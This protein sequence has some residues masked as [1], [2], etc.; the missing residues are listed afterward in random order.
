MGLSPRARGNRCW[1][2]C[3]LFYKG[4]IPACAGEPASS[5]PRVE[6]LWAYPRVRGGTD[7]FFGPDLGVWGLSPRARGNPK[8]GCGPGEFFGPIPACAGEPRLRPCS[9]SSPAAYPR[10][11]G[12]TLKNWCADTATS[13]LSPRARGNLCGFTVHRSMRGPI[14]ACAGEPSSS[15]IT[16]RSSGAY[17]RVRGGTV[18]LK[19]AQKPV[20][21][22][23]PRAR[24]NRP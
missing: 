16:R 3:R 12:G 10:V 1:S 8:A 9:A 6:Y 19:Q 4:P 2:V 5:T 20:E 7:D 13:G 23:S 22:L 21:G 11:R 14:P 18:Q 17:P 15:V 24:G